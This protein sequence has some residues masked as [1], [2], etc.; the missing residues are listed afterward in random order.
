[1]NKILIPL[2]LISSNVFSQDTKNDTIF[3]QI[4]YNQQTKWRPTI[5]ITSKYKNGDVAIYYM[6]Y[7]NGKY[8]MIKNKHSWEF[9]PNIP[10]K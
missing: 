5:K 7:K 4:R 6:E 3:G 10:N 1:M 9:K 2:L 8:R